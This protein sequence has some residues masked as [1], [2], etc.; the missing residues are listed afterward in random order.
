MSH[1]H[2]RLV[3][4][5]FDRCKTHLLLFKCLKMKKLI[6]MRHAKSAWNTNAPTDHARP[7]NERGRKSALLIANKLKELDW[8]P[9]LVLGSDSVRT[10]ETWMRMEVSFFR[11]PPVRYF[12]E[13]YHGDLTDLQH[14]IPTYVPN[15]IQC[16]LLLGH[17]PG[18]EEALC[19]LSGEYTRMT[20]ANA[21]LLRSSEVEW[22]KAIL[23]LGQWE[24]E[25]ILRP[26]EL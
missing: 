2:F 11:C 16:L 12:S 25:R 23:S 24:C 1:L 17:N 7:L 18:W 9:N 10:Q 20:T 8:I 22:S 6:L 19:Q 3:V 26:K 13:L 4:N 14:I 15:D 21:A 5:E